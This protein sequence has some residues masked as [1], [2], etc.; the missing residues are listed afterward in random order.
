MDTKGLKGALGSK[1]L[2]GEPLAKYTTFGIG[3][4]ADLLVVAQSLRDLC[5]CVREAFAHH[6]PY[7][8]LGGGANVLVS[9][10]GVRGLVIQNQCRNVEITPGQD[11]QAP[12]VKAESGAL[13]ATVA[14]E[15]MTH[16]LA[17]LEWAVD[18]PGT[19]GGGVVGN[20]GA[21]GGYVS[22][23]LRGVSVFSPEE[24][25]RW[26]RT[27]ELGMDYR[28]SVFKRN[29]LQTGPPPVILSATFALRAEAA[30]TIQA[31]AA[32]YSKRRAEAQPSGQS[33]GSVFKRTV[34]YPAGFLIENAGLK[35]KR[36]GGAI[37]S[38][39]HANFILNDG[40]ATA[41]DVRALI[42]LVRA[43]VYE[44]FKIMLEL[45]IELVGD[46]QSF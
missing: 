12:L 39:Q 9:D 18:V 26:W 13:L 25:E 24:G 44:R 32:E 7:L 43:T 42:E 46:W 10:K 5:A 6:V 27:S 30:D 45:E 37:V 33:A 8:V 34:Q 31:R 38:P 15:T 36:I 35:G 17:G 28:T 4:P 2:E 16:G 22:D 19:V 29:K 11:G 40:T 14:D 21:Y 3:G 20:A 41:R 1:A 23:S